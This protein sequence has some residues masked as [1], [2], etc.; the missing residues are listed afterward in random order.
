M[1]NRI[2][3]IPSLCDVLHSMAPGKARREAI[4]ALL[5]QGRESEGWSRIYVNNKWQRNLDDPDLKK[6]LKKGVLKRE[7]DGGR[8]GKTKR[9]YKRQTALVLAV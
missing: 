2:S 4:V 8:M 9:S 1:Q 7:R 6:L 3:V 5:K